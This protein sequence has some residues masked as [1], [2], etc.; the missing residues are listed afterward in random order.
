MSFP[1][2]RVWLR[3]WGPSADRGADKVLLFLCLSSPPA[4][5]ARACWTE[6]LAM[7]LGPSPHC[8]RDWHSHNGCLGRHIVVFWR[9]K[10]APTL[11]NFLMWEVPLDFPLN[12][13]FIPGRAWNALSAERCTRVLV[14]HQ[15]SAVC[16]RL[17]W[18][19]EH[20]KITC[21]GPA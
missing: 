21:R 14:E 20:P 15:L 3:N 1:A 5:R 8:L 7:P 17:R 18:E 19:G 11:R 6:M 4:P 16:R 13:T 12:V 10:Q 9:T 2:G